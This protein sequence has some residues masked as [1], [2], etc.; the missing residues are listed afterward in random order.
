MPEFDPAPSED[1]LDA[2]RDAWVEAHDTRDRVKQVLAGTREPAPASAIADEARCS[3]RAAQKH[4]ERLAEEGIALRSTDSRGA[5][6]RRN[7]AYHRWKRANRLSIEHSVE[8]LLDRI[9]ELEDADEQY[10]ERFDAA[11][12]SDVTF[13]PD[14]ADHEALHARWEALNT[15]E[16]VRRDREVYDDALRLA[17]DRENGTLTAD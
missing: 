15:W 3:E 8:E 13:P 4:L 6:Y 9:A 12:P 10:R 14:D 2:E 5:R 7:D 1:A 17:R 16:S 11:A